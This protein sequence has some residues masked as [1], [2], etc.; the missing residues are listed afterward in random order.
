MNDF[1]RAV[2]SLIEQ[3]ENHEQVGKSS[4]LRNTD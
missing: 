2:F 3:G 1:V 4:N